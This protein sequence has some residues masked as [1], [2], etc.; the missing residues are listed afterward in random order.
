MV[1]YMVS[2]FFYVPSMILG[3]GTYMYLFYHCTL[4]LIN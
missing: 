2:S 3:I 1:R 4:D